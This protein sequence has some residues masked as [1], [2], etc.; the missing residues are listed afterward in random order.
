VTFGY[1]VLRAVSTSVMAL[2]GAFCAQRTRLRLD[3]HGARS[4]VLIGIAMGALVAAYVLAMDCFLFR[5][6]LA[7]DYVKVIELPLLVRTVYFMLRAFN[8]NVKIPPAGNAVAA[9]EACT[10]LGGN[11][12]NCY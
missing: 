10:R 7:Q 9:P 4:P 6:I 1:P 3:G 11:A 12:A 5:N 8:E 2:I